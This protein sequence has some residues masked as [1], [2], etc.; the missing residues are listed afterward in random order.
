MHLTSRALALSANKSF[1]P[2]TQRH[3]AM[4]CAREH[5][6]RGAMPLRCRSTPT[7]DVTS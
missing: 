4:H 6:W 3:S 5:T 1:D 7:L 2:N